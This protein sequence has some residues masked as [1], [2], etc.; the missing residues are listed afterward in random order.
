MKTTAKFLPVMVVLIFHLGCEGPR[1]Y[2]LNF[3]P[4]GFLAD[5]TLEKVLQME[6]VEANHTYHSTRMVYRESQFRVKYAGSESWAKSPTD[7]IETAA[8]IFWRRSGIFKKVNGY[9]SRGESDWTLKIQLNAIEMV[10]RD[11]RWL[12]RLALDMEIFDTEDETTILL[13][14]FDRSRELRG[15]KFDRLPQKITEIMHEELLK[16]AEKLRNTTQ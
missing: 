2:D 5:F 16:V 15:K 8:T 3:E 7:L 11:K 10:R 12:A 14:S 1:Y 6:D 13:H 9:Y 4:P